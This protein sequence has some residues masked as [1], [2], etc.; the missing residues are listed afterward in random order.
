METQDDKPIN[1][2]RRL[3][4]ERYD[5]RP[6]LDARIRAAARR[7]LAPRPARAWL[8]TSLARRVSP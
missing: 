3:L 5:A 4:R 1:A 8:P 7:A 6:G 2:S